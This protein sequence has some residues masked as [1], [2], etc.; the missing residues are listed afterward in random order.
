[1]G[2]LLAQTGG[3]L[4]EMASPEMVQA[5]QLAPVASSRKLVYG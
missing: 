2:D 4:L 3:S 1:M 5:K